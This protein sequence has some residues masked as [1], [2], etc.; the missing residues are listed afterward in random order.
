MPRIKRILVLLAVVG[1][2]VLGALAGG[3]AARNVV[4]YNVEGGGGS[5]VSFFYIAR[6]YIYYD[7]YYHWLNCEYVVYTD[8]SAQQTR[9]W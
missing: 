6:V 8:G 5:T 4:P 2:L 7:G 1:T 9:C 3:A